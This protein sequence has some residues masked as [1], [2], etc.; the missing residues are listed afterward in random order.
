[1]MR[2]ADTFYFLA[3]LNPKDDAHSA[4]LEHSRGP[5]GIL[6]SEWVLTE[7]ADAMASRTRRAGFI[8]LHRLFR[9]DPDVDIVP[10]DAE[11]FARSVEFFAAR[12]D[13]DWS[14]TDCSSFIVMHDRGIEDALT[15]DHHFE[16]AGFRA[17]LK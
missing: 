2:F 3:L 1:M 11:L 9:S 12:P 4:A 10:A 16:Q 17:L 6:T 13:K 15:G 8:D 14:L 5:G 7:L